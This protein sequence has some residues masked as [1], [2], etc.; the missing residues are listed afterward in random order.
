GGASPL[1]LNVP[2]EEEF[3]NKGVFYCATCDGPGFAKKAVAVAGGGD[4][5]ITEGL[6]LAKLGCRVTIIEAMPQLTGTRVLQDRAFANP[7]I[8]VKCGTRIE[9][10]TG[11]SEVKGLN[12]LDIK[13]GAKSNIAVNGLLVHIGLKPRTEYLKGVLALNNR[14]QVV[15]NDRMESEIP[16]VFAAGDV[17]SNS[18]MQIST[19]VGDGA[20]AAVSLCRYL[21]TR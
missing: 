18:A 15:V 21:R 7:G 8:Q 14:G 12:L 3:A 2:G 13:T 11:D 4:S 20:T 19:A 16:G 6:F 9:A 10:V 5:G 1:K 17:R